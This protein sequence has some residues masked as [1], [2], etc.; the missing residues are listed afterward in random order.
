MRVIGWPWSLRRHRLPASSPSAIMSPLADFLLEKDARQRRH[1]AGRG[2][3]VSRNRIAPEGKSRARAGLRRSAPSLSPRLKAGDAGGPRVERSPA[4][5]GESTE[6]PDCPNGE[7]ALWPQGFHLVSVAISA[8]VKLD[9]L[10][11]SEAHQALA[12]KPRRAS[13]ESI[14]RSLV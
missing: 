11:A 4:R 2:V 7:N 1:W 13:G 10:R 8:C 6:V 3:G 5:W 12:L 14:A 9:M